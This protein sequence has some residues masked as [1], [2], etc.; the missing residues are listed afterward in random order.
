MIGVGIDKLVKSTDSVFKLAVLAA[1][2]AQELSR[3]SNKLVEA[4]LTTKCT[5]IALQEIV[6]NKITYKSRDKAK[7]K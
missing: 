7:S 1:K 4:S 3:G 5:T 6:Q 2:R